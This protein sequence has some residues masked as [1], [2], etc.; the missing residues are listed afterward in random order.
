[1]AQVAPSRPVM[2]FVPPP[3]H[4]HP[5]ASSLS[6]RVRPPE[7]PRPA[8]DYCHACNPPTKNQL[9][10]V[11]PTGRGNIQTNG[12]V[13]GVGTAFVV[14]FFPC[15]LKVSVP[16]M[17]WVRGPASEIAGG[18]EYPYECWPCSE[19]AVLT[20]CLRSGRPLRSRGATGSST[21]NS[22][23][24]KAAA[25]YL[26]SQGKAWWM[27]WPKSARD[28]ETFLPCPC[29]TAVP[30]ALFSAGPLFVSHSPKTAL[31]RK[32]KRRLLG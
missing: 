26:E 32:C 2:K 21:A 16:F 30:Y 25:A 22:W 6:Q 27:E 3:A 9:D 20:T 29:H 8:S 23:D 15:G 19:I 7:N 14:T 24:Q 18:K 17:N 10:S 28:H 13:R 11:A 1:M 4:S 12:T 31:S 5:S